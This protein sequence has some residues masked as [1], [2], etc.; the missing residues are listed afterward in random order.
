MY[1][2]HFKFLVCPKC[3]SLM[4]LNVGYSEGENIIAGD[5]FCKRCSKSYP[6]LNGIPMFI[7][8][9]HYSDSFGLEWNIHSR[10]QYDSYCKKNISYERFFNETKWDKN[11]TG[12]L[13]IEAGSGSGRF[14]EQALKTNAMVI[15]FDSSSAVIAN[16]NSNGKHENL[17]I[18]QTSI[19]EM[20]FRDKIADKLFCFGVLQH[21]LQ[22]ELSFK[23]LAEKIK[24]G[25]E[26]VAD[27]YKL[28][29]FTILKS[30][31]WIRPFI[32]RV[33][34]KKLYKLCHFYVDTIWNITKLNKKLFPRNI[35]K[36]IN[37][38]MLVPDYSEYNL[39]ENILKEWAY[40]DMFDM[41]SP[42]YD[43]PQTIRTFRIWFKKYG[44]S[45]VDIKYGYNGIEGKGIKV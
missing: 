15:S 35:A 44:F 33:N 29:V 22:P 3:K 42:A 1:V 21:T 28:N 40:L 6:I 17:L 18:V 19:S 23:L 45:K 43:K 2:K 4:N 13:I 26:M 36:Q 24:A 30:K 38:Q 20:P 7:G 8:N 31:Y 14:T 9:T 27:V 25:G 32:K 41:L 5:M 39:D 11:L 10:T 34:K 16:Y 12:Q 37:W